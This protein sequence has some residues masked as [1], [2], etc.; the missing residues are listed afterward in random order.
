ML[1]EGTFCFSHRM[2]CVTSAV[3]SV[4][5]FELL[6]CGELGRSRILSMLNADAMFGKGRRKL[7]NAV[8]MWTKE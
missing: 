4:K 5:E 8:L 3:D 2:I 7:S 1:S 6:D